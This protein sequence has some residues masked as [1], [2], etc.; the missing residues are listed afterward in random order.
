MKRGLYFHLKTPL[1]SKVT[2]LTFQVPTGR[3]LTG[4]FGQTQ[5]WGFKLMLQSSN[6]LKCN[7]AA[8][9]SLSAEVLEHEMS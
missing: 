1:A 9:L 7:A 2:N 4:R 8:G 5:I 6:L 3:F